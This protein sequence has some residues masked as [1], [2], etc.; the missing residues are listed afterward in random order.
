[1]RFDTPVVLYY[2]TPSG[3]DP[4]SGRETEKTSGERVAL[5]AFVGVPSSEQQLF[6]YG[7]AVQDAIT[8]W[9]KRKNFPTSIEG[10]AQ[11]EVDEIFYRVI[12]VKNY[13]NTVIIQARRY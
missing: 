12:S 10:L 8:I 6:F 2:D 4:T 7:Q 3:Y 9:A 5:Y 1:M 13:K 11:V